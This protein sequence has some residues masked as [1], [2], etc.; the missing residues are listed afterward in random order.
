MTPSAPPSAA[1]VTGSLNWNERT[2]ERETPEIKIL[3]TSGT[4]FV[5]T[6]Q[7]GGLSLR[8]TV[9]EQLYERVVPGEFQYAIYGHFYRATGQPDMVGTFRCRRFRQYDV[10][11]V[12]SR[13]SSTNFTDLGDP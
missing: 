5:F 6:L 10:T 1:P 12:L 7:G 9:G 13:G 11:I 3:N 2:I 4:P 8:R